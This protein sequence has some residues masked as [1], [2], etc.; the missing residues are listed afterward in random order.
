[1][2]FDG[3]DPI[4][5]R[6]PRILD[7]DTIQR[8]RDRIDH[9]R[10]DNRT[11]VQHY[12]LTGFLRCEECERSLSGQTQKPRPGKQYQY[13]VH[14]GGKY[15]DCQ[16]F[17]T[18]PLPALERAVFTTIF[19]NTADVPAF[20]DAI[21][22]SL[23][24]EQHIQDLETHIAQN[25]QELQRI[26][27][28]LDKL[29]DAYLNETLQKATIRKKEQ[30]LLDAKTKIK[31]EL[32]RQQAQLQS[33]PDPEDVKAEAHTIRRE[34]LEEYGSRDRW[35]AM[36]YE[37]KKRLLHWLFDG[38]DQHGTPYGI[39]VNKEGH[40]NQAKIDY[41]LYGRITGLRTLKGDDINYLPED[42]EY[43][44]TNTKFKLFYHEI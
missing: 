14:P 1:M 21:Q 6:I 36:S 3:E 13:Y 2:Q 41:F 7:E 11:D 27:R 38:T 15:Q 34:L 32:N 30:A 29:V 18:I 9:N 17:R 23:P 10:T 33:L 43:K 4:T 19:E 8:I 12:A 39:Y 22:D 42:D 40:G 26:D 35:Q 5:F 20:E 25:E 44:T 31:D 16:A 37:E 28:E 24:D